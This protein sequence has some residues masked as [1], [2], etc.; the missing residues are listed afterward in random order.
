[1]AKR[2]VAAA[3]T[4]GALLALLCPGTATAHQDG[5]AAPLPHEVSGGYAALTLENRDMTL[6]VGGPAVRG[7]ADRSWFPVTGGG[8]DSETGDVD[9]ELGG[10]ALLTASAGSCPSPGSGWNWTAAP[11]ASPHARWSPDGPS[12]ASSRR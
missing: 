2:P 1:M 6:D 9:L 3:V 8:A 11:A 12:T 4:G 7:A 10:T 5:A